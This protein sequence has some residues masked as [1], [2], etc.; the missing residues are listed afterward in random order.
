MMGASPQNFNNIHLQGA[1]CIAVESVFHLS[2]GHGGDDASVPP[3]LVDCTL[4]ECD[5]DLDSAAQGGPQFAATKVLA[6]KVSRCKSWPLRLIQVLAI[7]SA[8]RCMQL[9]CVKCQSRGGLITIHKTLQFRYVGCFYHI[10]E[11]I[12][13]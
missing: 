9:F 6:V 10:N 12:L 13:F 3:S 2:E 5:S 8:K 1:E 7:A 11:S 4:R